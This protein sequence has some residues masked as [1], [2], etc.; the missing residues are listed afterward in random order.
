M[1]WKHTF[2]FLCAALISI[3]GGFIIIMHF[4]HEPHWP[5]DRFGGKAGAL[6][7]IPVCMLS[8]AVSCYYA[9]RW[10]QSV[11]F[12]RLRAIIP[13]PPQ[14]P[15]IDPHK[16]VSMILG[17]FLTGTVSGTIVILHFFHQPQWPQHT[18][19][20][21]PGAV[22]C[23]PI[24]IFSYSLCFVVTNQWLRPILSPHV[25]AIFP[26]SPEG[27][28]TDPRSRPNRPL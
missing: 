26:R 9:N 24:C 22:A 21:T 15:L 12:T 1:N 5:G 13:R 6:A 2:V 11:L 8:Y 28:P 23:I 27:S 19:R 16:R 4:H 18:F 10:L 20:G 7:L 3:V 17:S 25:R 14:E